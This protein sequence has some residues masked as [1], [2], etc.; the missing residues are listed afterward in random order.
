MSTSEP[1]HGA[2]PPGGPGQPG[3]SGAPTP[4]R[5][6]F[7]DGVPP[8]WLRRVTVALGV[9]VVLV[10]LGVVGSIVLPGW[11]AGVVTGWVQGITSAGILAGLVCGVVF[12]AL[13][14]GIIWFA[15]RAKWPW[16]TRLIV[17]AAAAVL[18]LPYVLTLVIDLGSTSSA[19]DARL[20]MVQC[21]PAMLAATM[22]RTCA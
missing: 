11:W 19:F 12:T 3:P 7:A 17:A 15:V 10:L 16:R 9:L 20:V 2:D 1:H 4:S 21:T 14:V 13:P 5:W 18:A 22:R 6:R 8:A